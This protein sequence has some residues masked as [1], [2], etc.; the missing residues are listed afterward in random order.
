MYF[1][2]HKSPSWISKVFPKRIWHMDRS[3]KELYLTFDDGH[4]PDVTPLILEI[5]SKYSAK[6]TF[7]QLGSKIL[8][9]PDL[10]KLCLE[11]GHVVGN[12]GYDHLDAWRV[13]PATFRENVKKGK[14]VTQ[15]DLY[16]PAYG[17]MPLFVKSK[18]VKD[19]IVVMW[20]VIS[21]DFD[22][23]IDATICR[24]IIIKHAQNGSI[25]V[26]HEN[27][28][29]KKKVLSLLPEILHYYLNKGF[30]FKA[31]E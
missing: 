20:D 13:M 14:E 25:V 23:R 7:F 15:S 26:L 3:K 16:R 18:I 17:R 27:E 6:V 31:I 8:K 21:G 19:N 4:D 22:K 11:Q 29:S 12:H 2:L 1:Y 5:L 30:E 24:K 10:H 9:H 28:K